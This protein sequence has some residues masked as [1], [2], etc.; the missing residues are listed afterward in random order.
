MRRRARRCMI[1]SNQ[2]FIDWP[3]WPRFMGVCT[4]Q[5]S[6]FRNVVKLRLASPVPVTL[7][8]TKVISNKCYALVF[9]S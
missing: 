3:L 7:V 9:T 8:N 2:A 6:S 4:W 5:D 1:Q